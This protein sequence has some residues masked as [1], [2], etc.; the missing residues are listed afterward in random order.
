V[1]RRYFDLAVLTDFDGTIA[2]IVTDPMSAKP[3]AQAISALVEISKVA[4]LVGVVSGRPL[5][6]LRSQLPGSLFFAALVVGSYGEEVSLPGTSEL[7]TVQR[8]S[9]THMVSTT[10]RLREAFDYARSKVTPEIIELEEKPFSFTIHYRREPQMRESV[11]LLSQEIVSK[12]SLTAM[13]AKMAKEFFFGQK[14]SKGSAI[15]R[16]TKEFG[17][18]VYMGDD[19]SD[20][21]VFEYL[22]GAR[23]FGH[24]SLS[25]AVASSESPQRLVEAADFFVS[26]PREA[27]RWLHTLSVAVTRNCI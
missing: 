21:E 27:G 2:D 14:P 3:Q 19:T 20:L 4:G 5:D 6:F 18:I 7:E 11:E 24:C 10:A 25:V 8:S 23:Q 15:E 1:R 9:A 26:S 22:K 13:D 12:F 16:F 17:Y